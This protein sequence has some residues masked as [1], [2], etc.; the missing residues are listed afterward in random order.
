V[1]TVADAESL[2]ATIKQYIEDETKKA[3]KQEEYAF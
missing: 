2:I 1:A 3:S